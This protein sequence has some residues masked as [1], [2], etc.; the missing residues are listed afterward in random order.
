MNIKWK[1]RGSVYYIKHKE[2][3]KGYV[4]QHNK[5]DPK[6]R[7]RDH[8][9]RANGNLSKCLFHNAL[10]KYGIDAFT[11]E[12]LVVCAHD[13]LTEMEGYYAEVFGTYAWDNSPGGYNAVWCSDNFR[14]GTKNSPEAIEKVRRAN[15]GRKHS[16]EAIEKTRQASLARRH[17]PESIEKC[18]QSSLGRKHSPETIEKMRQARLAYHAKKSNTPPAHQ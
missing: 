6:D 2:S 8:K 18:R 3:G 4:G 7:W 1:V 15:L 13:K 16:P 5:P 14:L 17:S 11:W 10:K 9:A 12:V